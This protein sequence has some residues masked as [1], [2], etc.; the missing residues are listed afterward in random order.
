MS[1]DYFQRERNSRIEIKDEGLID[2]Y[3]W[4]V[5]W[6][7]PLRSLWRGKGA[8]ELVFSEWIFEDHESRV[9]WN[10]CFSLWNP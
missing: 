3:H 8:F 5:R 10:P 2:P 7:L 1:N 9:A 6:D 4:T